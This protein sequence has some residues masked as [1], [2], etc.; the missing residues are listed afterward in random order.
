MNIVTEM[1]SLQ[2][3]VTETVSRQV[4]ATARDVRGIVS[5]AFDEALGQPD[6]ATPTN[7]RYLVVRLDRD[8]QL[9]EQAFR[10]M[11]ERLPEL[12]KQRQKRLEEKDI[13]A[14]LN[15][16]APG[17]PADNPQTAIAFDNAAAR[18][19][20]LDE[21][22][23]L[24]SRQVAEQAG[25]R[26]KNASMTASRWKQAER[27][28][29]VPRLGEELYPAFQFRD[30]QPHPMIARVL[31]ALPKRKRP[32]QVAFWFTSS[33]GWLDGDTPANRLD[34]GDAVVEAARREAEELVG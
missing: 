22:S 2:R 4:G 25:H 13:E 5:Q 27:L 7:T 17:L 31:A 14:L 8:E 23:C 3:T 6:V 20:F 28:F 9:L 29:S 18:A 24:G 34:G 30:G 12:L 19:R 10:T 1:A 21:V 15:I 26:A 11:A 33:N 16:L 32:W